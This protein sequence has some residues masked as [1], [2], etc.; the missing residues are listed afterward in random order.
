MKKAIMK[1]VK[2]AVP[3]VPAEKKVKL[4]KYS[5]ERMVSF[6]EVSIVYAKSIQEAELI[7]ENSDPNL[8]THIGNTV[9]NTRICKD[10]DYNR[11]K[12]MDPYFFKGASKVDAEG[13]LMYIDEQGKPNGNMPTEKIF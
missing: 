12:S 10:E 6:Y 11:F 9:I 3:A 2:K 1:T 13:Y 8:S 4:Q 7:A 5:V